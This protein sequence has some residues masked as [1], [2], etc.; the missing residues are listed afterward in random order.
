MKPNITQPLYS[1]CYNVTL[2]T[3]NWHTLSI[4]VWK[5][6]P[7]IVDGWPGIGFK[8]YKCHWLMATKVY[9]IKGLS[10]NLKPIPTIFEKGWFQNW[11]P[12][13][14][15]KKGSCFHK[16]LMKKEAPINI[17]PYSKSI[18][19]LNLKGYFLLPY[20]VCPVIQVHVWRPQEHTSL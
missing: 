2:A 20:L 4:L 6:Y 5:F 9:G 15:T 14:L 11:F 18:L 19:P 7:L 17:T 16:A 10:S 3:T 12:D 1:K 8:W 13:F